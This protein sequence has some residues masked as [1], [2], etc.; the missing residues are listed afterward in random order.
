MH[1]IN[2]NCFFG[3]TIGKKLLDSCLFYLLFILFYKA[4]QIKLYVFDVLYLK[5]NNDCLMFYYSRNSQK[6]SKMYIGQIDR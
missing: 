3:K 5:Q 6:H 2:T 1:D 4:I